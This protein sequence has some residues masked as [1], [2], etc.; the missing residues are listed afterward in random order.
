MKFDGKLYVTWLSWC[1]L[2]KLCW[3]TFLGNFKNK[4]CF[5]KNNSCFFFCKLWGWKR[6]YIITNVFISTRYDYH[7]LCS[8]C[9]E[10]GEKWWSLTF[11]TKPMRGKLSEKFNWKRI[12]TSCAADNSNS[13]FDSAW[14]KQVELFGI[15]MKIKINL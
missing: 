5:F 14:W 8:W 6:N 1:L 7:A 12:Q 10:I 3:R 11:Y 13:V 15:L 2:I 9:W 4:L